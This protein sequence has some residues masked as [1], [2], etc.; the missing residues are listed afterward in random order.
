MKKFLN[1][2]IVTITSFALVLGFAGLITVLAATNPS[3]GMSNSFGILSSTYTNISAGTVNGDVGYTTPPVTPTTVTGLIHVADITY[4]QA[5]LDQNS[6]LVDLNSQPCDFNF[7]S[8]TD[9]SLE[10]QPLI[11][12]VYC[13]TGAQSI[14]TGGITLNGSGTYI[15]RS[16]GALTTVTGSSVTLAGGAS[17][18]DVFWT[19]IQAT[20]LAANTDFTGTV[21]DAAGITVGSTVTWLGR[22]LAFG[23]TVTTNTDTITVPTCTVPAPATLHVIK[24]VVNHNSTGVSSDFNLYV[25]LSGVNIAGSPLA[26]AVTPG[27]TYTISAGTYVVSEDL[28]TA[29]SSSFSGDCNSNGTIILSASDDKTC[30]ITNTYIVPTVNSGGRNGGGGGFLLT[31][32]QAPTQQQIITPISNTTT[33]SSPVIFPIPPKFPNTGFAPRNIF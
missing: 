14:G 16:T 3:L 25:K 10:S 8:A 7:G 18:C 24:T 21:I 13:V 30:T 28:N 32:Q 15:F 20:T 22:A 26:G 2:K 29:Y 4:N 19:P 5:G 33:T 12:G 11:P 9:L 23:G 31:Q 1:N 6:S 27:N 17:A